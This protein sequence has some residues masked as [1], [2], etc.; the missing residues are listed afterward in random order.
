MAW[1][2]AGPLK[3]NPVVSAAAAAIIWSFVIWCAADD[4]AG[5][6][7]SIWKTW[8]AESWSWLYIVSQDVWILALLYVLANSQYRNI[9]LGKD[10]EKPEYSNLTWFAMMFSCGVAVG[11][12]YYSVAEPVWHYTGGNRFAHLPDNERGTHS[13][14]VTWYHWGLHGWIPYTVV[15]AVL[16]LMAYRRDLPMTMRFTLYPLIGERVYGWIGDLVDV[17]SICCTLFGVCTSLGLGVQ[18]I[19]TGLVRLDKGTFRGVDDHPDGRTGMEVNTDTQVVIIWIVT[20]LATA[21]VVAGLQ[22]GIRRIAQVTFGLGMFLML[23]VLF[24]GHTEFIL[25]LIVETFGYYLWYLPKISFH[26][27]AF[28][29]SGQTPRQCVEELGGDSTLCGSPTWMD[30]W[31]IFYWGWWISWGPFVGM[32]MAKISRGRT[33]GEFIMGTLIVPSAYSFLWLGIFG[34]EGI[35]MERAAQIEGLTC[36]N[37]FSA[38]TNNVR[39]SCSGTAAMYFD[40]V[41]SYGSQG[42]GDFIS[43]LSIIALI[44]YFVASSDS[45]SLVIDIIAANGVAN[46]PVIQKVFWAFSEGAAATALLVAGGSQALSALQTASIVCGLPYTFVLFWVT[47]ALLVAVKEEAGEVD[48]ER[49]SLRSFLLSTDFKKHGF[50]SSAGDIAIAMHVPFLPMARIAGK[51]AGKD[52][53]DRFTFVSASLA[54]VATLMFIILSAHEEEWM[55]ISAS[56]YVLMASWMGFLRASVRK[57]VGCDRGNYFTDVLSCMCFYF[58]ALPQMEAELETV[59]ASTN[60]DGS[61]VFQNIVVEKAA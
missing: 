18:Q 13:L 47:Q 46:P 28:E 25:N 34:A 48:A 61:V 43:L 7:L 40:Q 50:F 21:S 12:F 60:P 20:V 15:G 5:A 6:E 33:L 35:Y 45:G 29:L 24:L 30:G 36:D 8:V 57:A 54:W 51:L 55:M 27:D 17:A 44:L 19:N 3:F 38:V 37:Q 1:F 52:S 9:K 56:I 39:L 32:F 49:K 41:T 2:K 10:D 53:A 14:M 58:L 42:F 16:G 4:K 11:I 31:T 59:V 22:M 23:S 26:T